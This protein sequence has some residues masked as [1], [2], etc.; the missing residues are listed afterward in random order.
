MKTRNVIVSAVILALAIIGS[1][2]FY[3]Q[4]ELKRFNAS[5]PT[6]PV[7]VQEKENSDT[8]PQHSPNGDGGLAAHTETTAVTNDGEERLS[9]ITEAVPVERD[10]GETEGIS[11]LDTPPEEAPVEAV[12]VSPFGFG[13]YPEVPPDFPPLHVSWHR[14]EE[15]M[16][17]FNEDIRIKFELMSRVFIKLW[18]QGHTELE[19]GTFE[20]GLV[21]PLY[22][23]TVY[24]RYE[25]SWEDVETG[26]IHAVDSAIL[27]GSGVSEAETEQMLNGETP[28]G[29]RILAFSDG[30]D[31]YM[32][33]DLP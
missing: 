26:D 5:L 30:I 7:A 16:A 18:N 28:P 21:L 19:G 32:F 15:V 33:L 31:P 22:P 17:R 13:P 9:E 4:W 20:N 14:P 1:I 23:N 12:R 24:L 8:E 6:P 29:I 25:E 27:V 3:A 2:S 10:I 11:W